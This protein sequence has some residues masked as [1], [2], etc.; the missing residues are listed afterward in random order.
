MQNVFSKL[1]AEK[2]TA[3]LAAEGV[4][5]ERSQ[6]QLYFADQRFNP[7]KSGQLFQIFSTCARD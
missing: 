3:K 2:E 7:L 4:K 1:L 6:L 5:P